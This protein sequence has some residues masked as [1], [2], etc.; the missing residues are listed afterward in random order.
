MPKLV[1]LA[2]PTIE[3][4]YTVEIV[5]STA[6]VA[7]ELNKDGSW[8]WTHTGL[9]APTYWET[10]ETKVEDGQVVFQ[11]RNG[12]EY[13]ANEVG[14]LLDDGRIMPLKDGS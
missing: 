5:I 2:D 1:V 8:G 9:D 7:P 11:T 14:V 13:L 10:S 12:D 6:T 4:A 3:I